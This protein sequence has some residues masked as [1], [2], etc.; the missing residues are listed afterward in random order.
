MNS[1]ED[2][3]RI[4]V[5]N[6][7]CTSRALPLSAAQILNINC[8]PPSNWGEVVYNSP[9]CKLAR[10]IGDPCPVCYACCAQEIDQNNYIQLSASCGVD[11]T[12]I[13]AALAN[14][15]QRSKFLPALLETI[16]AEGLTRAVQN[17]QSVQSV[18]IMGV[19]TQARIHQRIVINA[20]MDVLRTPEFVKA[21]NDYTNDTSGLSYI[22]SGDIVR[23]FAQVYTAALLNA[24]RSTGTCVQNVQVSQLS[25]IDCATPEIIAQSAALAASLECRNAILNKLPNPELYCSAC[26][27]SDSSQN[28]IVSFTASCAVNVPAAMANRA[29]VDWLRTPGNTLT[30]AIKYPSDNANY[31]NVVNEIQAGLND[32]FVNQIYQ[33]L[34]AAQNITATVNNRHIVG[35]TQNGIYNVV[36]KAVLNNANL[37]NAVPNLAPIAPKTPEPPTQVGW[38]KYF[39]YLILIVLAAY[40]AAQMRKTRNVGNSRG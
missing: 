15:L 16:T 6:L 33:G 30:P 28:V 34:V 9:A 3:A 11:I 22:D 32:E 24:F 23:N 37:K 36:L 29:I 14:K 20:V 5:D 17:V 38:G 18:N 13:R 40:F 25:S 10:E 8:T 31:V 19:G 12:K 2:I 27:V 4:I 1:A 21:L 39:L 26:S 7:G 35:V